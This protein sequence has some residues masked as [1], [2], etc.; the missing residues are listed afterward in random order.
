MASTK[1]KVLRL[2]EW[3]SSEQHWAELG[4]IAQIVDCESTNRAQFFEDLKTKYSDIT[5]IVRTFFSVNHTGRF[6]AE[7]AANLPE[8]VR[9]ISHNG[10]GYDQI[11]VQPFTDRGIQVSN[12]TTPVEAPTALTAVYLTL[13]AM[14]NF[15]HG[16]DLLVQGK[17]PSGKCAGVPMGLDPEG[18]T[19]GIVGMGGIGRAIRD[20][21]QPFG[22]GKFIYYN[23]SKLSAELEQGAEYVSFDELLAQAD[24]VLLSVPLNAKTR[25]LVNADVL[26]KMKKGVVIVNTAR[27]AVI[28]EAALTKSLQEGHVGAFGSDVF[29]H[30]P[31]L[32]P[33]LIA[34]PNVVSLPHMGTHSVQ[35]LVN[36]EAFV[37][38]NVQTYLTT[39]KML[40]NVPE[41]YGVEFKH[42]VLVQ[43]EGN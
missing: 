35:A 28:D 27:G 18:K 21:L 12:I 22:F 23:R 26:G 13:A 29:E 15:Q 40:T 33:E 5:S 24:V 38:K 14:R 11:D 34:L 41:Q 20:R 39:G 9:S 32:T 3:E 37:V 31:E 10:A 42:D 17:W 2:G 30:E 7:L 19:V 43:A 25:H 16:H 36:M 4:K 6:D 8:S 1:P